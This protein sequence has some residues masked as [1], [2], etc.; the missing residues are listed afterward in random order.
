MAGSPV[1]SAISKKVVLL[2]VI[3]RLHWRVL[4]TLPSFRPESRSQQP[5][6]VGESRCVYDVV[7]FQPAA[8]RLVDPEAH[9][10]EVS[11]AMRIR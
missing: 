9:E 8:S 7:G 6:Q 5:S 4:D 10:I 2:S 1:S 3:L 11:H